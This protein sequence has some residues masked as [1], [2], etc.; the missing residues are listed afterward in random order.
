M[1]TRVDSKPVVSKPAKGSRK[2][3]VVA[4]AIADGCDMELFDAL[5]QWRR[6]KA[7]AMGKGVPAYVI[8]PDA[9]LQE[10]ARTKPKTHD[11]LLECRGIGPAKARQYGKE[12]L[13]FIRSFS[14]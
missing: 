13:E 8:Y 4:A 10:I 1:P 5:R 2:A 7:A 6:D 14:S 12:T 3:A 9:T 11:E